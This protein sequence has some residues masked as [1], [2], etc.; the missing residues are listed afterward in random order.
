MTATVSLPSDMVMGMKEMKYVTPRLGILSACILCVMGFWIFVLQHEFQEYLQ[1]HDLFTEK[2]Q[3]F[4][5]ISI[6]S[7]SGIVFGLATTGCWLTTIL[8][9]RFVRW[10]VRIGIIGSA[11]LLSCQFPTLEKTNWLRE[12]INF[13]GLALTQCIL[14]FWIGVPNWKRVN[15]DDYEQDT[16]RQYGIGDIVITTTVVAILLATGIRYAAPIAPLTYWLVLVVCWCVLS[17]LA[18]GIIFGVLG[19][20]HARQ[21]ISLGGVMVMATAGVFALSFAEILSENPANTLNVWV[22]SLFAENAL[23][24]SSS[25]QN[26]VTVTEYAICYGNFAASYLATVAFVAIAGR[27]QKRKNAA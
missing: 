25:R 21:F 9:S 8:Q 27:V 10:I 22:D 12:L 19:L 11:V 7:L 2:A 13:S 4:N 18:A 17:F 6:I 20:T 14:F 15:Q 5:T 3:Q 23:A 16:K 26:T 1:Q 24:D